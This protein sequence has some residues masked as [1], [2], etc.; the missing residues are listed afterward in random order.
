MN[1]FNYIKFSL[2]KDCDIL[3]SELPKTFTAIRH[4]SLTYL[5]SIPAR[6]CMCCC[7]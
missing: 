2:A 1:Q 4:Q 5:L 6:M 3:P 7:H